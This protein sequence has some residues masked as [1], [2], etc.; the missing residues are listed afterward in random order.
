MEWNNCHTA[1]RIGDRPTRD[2]MRSH[3]QR[4][5]DR[6]IFSSA[7]RRLQ[8]KTQV[9]PLPGSTFVH[10]RLTHSL[11]VASVGRSLGTLLGQYISTFAGLDVTDKEFYRQD[12][13]NIIAAGCLAHDI[14]N[15]AFGHSGEDAI[16]NYFI[17]YADSHV[18]RQSLRSHFSD[19][20]WMDL[21]SFEGNANALRVLAQDF[22]GK[23]SGGGKYCQSG[24]KYSSCN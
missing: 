20:E 15:P 16:S 13:P 21:T 2:V 9:F 22:N 24:H 23:A 11:E 10:N 5:Y 17:Q 3:Y 8:S 4:D 14:G 6:L 12:L 7:F 19:V 1:R 18:E